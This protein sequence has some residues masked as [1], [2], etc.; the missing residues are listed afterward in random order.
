MEL[1]LQEE[2]AARAIGTEAVK[3][4]CQEETL[5]KI[6]AEVNSQALRTLEK[7]REILNDDSLSDP[8]CFHR[9]EA[10]VNALESSGIDTT[11]HDW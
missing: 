9:I 6:T 5:Q 7:I 8:E 3:Y 1:S 11:R 10:V 2:L 4:L